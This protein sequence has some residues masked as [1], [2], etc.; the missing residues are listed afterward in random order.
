LGEAYRGDG[1]TDEAI[2]ND[3][4]SLKLNPKNKNGE[5]ILGKVKAARTGEIL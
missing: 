2:A 4:R 5:R 3:R 1:D